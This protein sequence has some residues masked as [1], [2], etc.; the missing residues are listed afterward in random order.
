MYVLKYNNDK[1]TVHITFHGLG[2]TALCGAGRD[3]GFDGWDTASQMDTLAQSN[4]QDCIR[5]YVK[6]LRWS[7][8]LKPRFGE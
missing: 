8:N 7:G 1:D 5:R 4:C 6:I 2:S 3:Q